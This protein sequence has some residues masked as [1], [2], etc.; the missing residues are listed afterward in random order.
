MKYVPNRRGIKEL[1]KSSGIGDAALAAAK[2]G[3][4]AARSIAPSESGDYAASISAKKQTVH[5]GY[6]NDERAGA[7]YGAHVD[8]ANAVEAR[9]HTMR[10]SVNRIHG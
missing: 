7:S 9:H 1:G 3:V 5:V 8:Y 6:N 10:E 4:E 2:K